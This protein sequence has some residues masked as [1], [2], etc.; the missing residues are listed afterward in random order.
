[1]NTS[2][3]IVNTA[4]FHIQDVNDDSWFSN[5]IKKFGPDNFLMSSLVSFGGVSF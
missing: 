1:M 4:S 2:Y 3:Y 5:P